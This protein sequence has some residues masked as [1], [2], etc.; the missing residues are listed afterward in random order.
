[1]PI[2]GLCEE[3]GSKVRAS[4]SGMAAPLSI[5]KD[6]IRPNIVTEHR[7]RHEVFIADLE[8]CTNG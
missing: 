1:M 6:I 2:D 3:I 4:R 7:T 8:A 5:A